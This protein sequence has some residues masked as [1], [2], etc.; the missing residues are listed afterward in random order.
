M[1]KGDKDLADIMYQNELWMAEMKLDDPEFF[2]KLGA[3]HKPGYFWIGE[4]RES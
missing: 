2:D 4:F 3:T 1:K